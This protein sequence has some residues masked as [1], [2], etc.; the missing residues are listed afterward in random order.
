MKDERKTKRELI[1]ELQLLRRR[2]AEMEEPGSRLRKAEAHLRKEIEWKVFLLEL[3]EKSFLLSD[4]DLYGYV[5]DQILRLTESTIGF[6]HL[7]SDDQKTVILTCWNREALNNCTAAYDAHYPIEQAGNWVDCVRLKRPV[8]YNDFPDSPN[9]KGLPEG[10]TPVKRFMSIPVVDGARV[11]FIFGVGNKTEKYDDYDVT[12]IQ[13]AANDL[14]RIIRQ[15]R[16]EEELRR[17]ASTIRAL[18]D[19]T[20]ESI[21]LVD[22][23]GMVLA[24][25][26]AGAKRFNKTTEE[27]AGCN[28]FNLLPP[29]LVSSRQARFREVISSGKP[30]RFE[31]RRGSRW[32][33]N[34]FYPVM[35]EDGKV[36]A[37]AHYSRDIS[38]RKQAEEALRESEEKYR[39]I[40]NSAM[41]GIYQST[42][43]GRYLSVNPAM[44]RMLGYGSPEELISGI[45]DIGQQLY[46][47]PRDRDTLK[48]ILAKKGSVNNF[49]TRYFRK[50]GSVIWIE[51]SARVVYGPDGGISH[52]EGIA[53]NITDRRNAEEQIRRLNAELERRVSERTAELQTAHQEIENISYSI[54]HDLRTP[55]RAIDGF[56][57]ILQND[58]GPILPDEANRYVEILRTNAQHMG[59]LLEAM[60]NFLSINRRTIRKAP[61]HLYD[62]AMSSLSGFDA[63]I[64]ER[65]IE[66]IVG[67]MP[68]CEA[69]P[70]MM[71][72]VFSNLI[73]NAV[74][75]TGRKN[76][77]RI[78]IGSCTGKGGVVCFVRDN[79]VGFDMKYIDKV[80]G[81]FQ[82]LHRQ[83][84]FQGA[85]L[86]LAIAQSIIRRHGG[87]IW[88]ESVPEEG[89]TMFFTME[90]LRLPAGS[91]SGDMGKKP[92]S[93]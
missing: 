31:D 64:E 28:V 17:G 90:G 21:F 68:S 4:R 11:I 88:A 10:H 61:L 44:A 84:E 78:E 50:D 70:V 5:L 53:E 86:G 57:R 55:L 63:E 46:V 89:T 60:R 19:A 2:I 33:D 7:V 41:E 26:E 3:Y 87:R 13:L 71:K 85:G 59:M 69:D 40:F 20:L 74:K 8:V 34:H 38:E 25:N 22:T 23:E 93:L 43:A 14:Q 15:R 83:D 49:A 75:F 77:A 45:T 16:S 37:V 52:Y 18:F 6:F 51:Y 42:P 82:R 36:T 29:D 32:L 1:D 72:A 48:E 80:F 47:D 66:T 58:Y 76:P 91:P 24:A 73:S 54:S 9:R 35:N 27:I 81:A 12:Q 39:T 92:E 79:G 30:M 65:G 56:S 67:A 62:I